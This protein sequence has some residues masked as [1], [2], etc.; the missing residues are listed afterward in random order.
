MNY[1]YHIYLKPKKGV[2]LEPLEKSFNLALDWYRYAPNSWVVKSNQTVQKWQDRLL[3][4]VEPDGVLLILKIDQTG[5][6]GWISKKFWEWF[7]A[8]REDDE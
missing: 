4:H 7:K 3:K 1:F 2:D 8:A 6:Q 5:R